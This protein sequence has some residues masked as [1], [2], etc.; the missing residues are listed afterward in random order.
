MLRP[1]RF[2]ALTVTLSYIA[3]SLVVL[4][5]FATPIQYAW[6]EIV[7]ERSTERLGEDAKRLSN[8]LQ[9]HGADS[10]KAVIGA[11][12]E[13]QPIG[14]EKFILLTDSAFN[15]IAG[16]L[17]AW[18]RALPTSP[19]TY[20]L[21]FDL[22]R[23]LVRAI[24]IRT[25]LDNGDNL[26]VGRN[27]SKFQTVET[28]FW[29]G[30]LGAA[31]TVLVFGTFGGLLIRRALLAEVHGINQ[32]TAAIMSGDFSRRLT[33]R[34]GEN[35]FDMLAQTVNRMLD[36]IENLIHGISNVSNAIAHDLRTPLTELRARLEVLAQGR[37]SPQDTSA[38][39][40]TAVAD[41]DRVIAIFNALLRMAEIDNGARRAGFVSVDIVKVASDAA[42][43]YQPLAELKEI[44]LTFEA[45]GELVTLGDPLLLA[46]AIGNLI[47]NALKYARKKIVVAL[48]ATQRDDGPMTIT[49]SDDGPGIPDEEKSKVVE[50]FYRGD[51]SRGTPGIGLGLS[52]VASVIKLHGGSLALSDAR[53]G[54]RATLS[55]S[56]Q[57]A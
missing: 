46:Q 52:L 17:P 27:T 14:D 6:H 38:E 35:E 44:S 4:I 45:K 20:T 22:N 40:E 36:Q 32:T 47:D 42:E 2:S 31:T 13:A 11:M 49:V 16:N 34:G 51:A 8:V 39:I 3:V 53:P 23:R 43:F 37:I 48:D 55:M 41:V 26:V 15:P 5:L 19:G 21:S 24:F 28:L 7:Q 56:R 12:V 29:V 25:R 10:L 18:P 50:R 57:V 33:R 30:L 9:K 54:L 1:L